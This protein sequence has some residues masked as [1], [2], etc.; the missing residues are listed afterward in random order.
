MMEA[1][2]DHLQPR[3]LEWSLGVIVST[4]GRRSLGN[5]V[6]AYSSQEEAGLCA[7]GPAEHR[8]D[9]LASADGG[10][11]PPLPTS[12]LGWGLTMSLVLEEVRPQD[13][14]FLFGNLVATAGC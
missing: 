8:R 3:S 9:G 7:L 1:H 6:T 2:R 14:K 10:P 4:R 12:H 13:T 5:Q 11:G